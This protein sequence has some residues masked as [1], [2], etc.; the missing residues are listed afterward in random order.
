[1]G[2]P[3]ILT[4]ILDTY[5]LQTLVELSEMDGCCISWICD[6]LSMEQVYPVL[7]DMETPISEWNGGRIS[8]IIVLQKLL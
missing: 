4:A 1:M 3:E 8:S 2:L 6:W 7:V 5:Y